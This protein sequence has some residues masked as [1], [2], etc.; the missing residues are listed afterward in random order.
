MTT[1]AVAEQPAAEPMEERTVHQAKCREC[2]TT[3][4]F[5]ANAT[6]TGFVL[7]G[8]TAPDPEATF[9]ASA[10]GL[11]LCPDGH[12]EMQ[13]TDEQIPAADAIRQVAEQ[14]NGEAQQMGLPGVG[15]ELFNYRDCYLEFEKKFL[16]RK[17]LKD[18]EDEDHERYKES[19]KKRE[20]CDEVISKMGL[21]FARWRAEKAAQSRPGSD[22]A[23]GICRFEQLHPGVPCPLPH[24]GIDADVLGSE[25]HGVEANN[26]LVNRECEQTIAR[27]ALVPHVGF[28]VEIL[29]GL[30]IEDLSMLQAWAGDF[31]DRDEAGRAEL[32]KE[33]PKALAKAHIAGEAVEGTQICT[34]CGQELFFVGE[35]E[36][37]LP[38]GTLVGADC[39]G[40]AKQ[41]GN[42]Y[43]DKKKKASRR[44]AAGE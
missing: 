22:T 32:L 13:I 10:M 4:T 7:V 19:K 37:P 18:T 2:A 12:G 38:V 42:R 30:P 25:S 29:R 34:E 36:S 27:L 21:E 1:A 31:E 35:G 28:T 5:K 40:K 16:E 3:V 20:K 11:P 33:L 15:A 17:L 14:V 44:R 39:Q 8:H 9:G 43:P 41:V 23:I 24:D 26:F 6:G